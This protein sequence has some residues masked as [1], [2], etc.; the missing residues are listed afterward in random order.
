MGETAFFST[1]ISRENERTTHCHGTLSS[2]QNSLKMKEISE[3]LG[4]KQC[5]LAFFHNS[6]FESQM[7]CSLSGETIFQVRN[8]LL[9]FVR[10]KCIQYLAH[11]TLADPQSGNDEH[12]M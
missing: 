9:E 10:S 3:L 5:A 1:G 6:Y 4:Q 11:E 7:G 2:Y 8:S 12:W